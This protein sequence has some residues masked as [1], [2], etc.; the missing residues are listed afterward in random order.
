MILYY[1]YICF[2]EELKTTKIVKQEKKAVL[3][4]GTR[5]HC[6]HHQIQEKYQ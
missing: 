5:L 1:K 2:Q 3:T 4:I 6:R